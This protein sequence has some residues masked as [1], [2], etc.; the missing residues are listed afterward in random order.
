MGEGAGEVEGD[1]RREEGWSIL[2]N[3][4]HEAARNGGGERG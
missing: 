3:E 2:R 4:T 1:R